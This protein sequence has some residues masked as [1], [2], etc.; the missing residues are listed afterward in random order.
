MASGLGCM[1]TALF[2]G[3]PCTSYTQ[4]IGIVAATGVAS[5]RVTQVAG[6]MFLLYGLCPKLAYV[7]AGIPK[8]IIGAVFLISAASI[9]FSGIDSIVSSPRTLKNTFIAGITLSMAVMLPYHC[10][11]T[12]A[13]WANSLSPFMNMLCTS[14]V[15]IAV[16]CGVT[17]NI[18]LN[19]V[20]KEKE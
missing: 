20:L 4:N 1:I 3:L 7:L 18:L 5:R 13:D 14:P 8:P 16:I 6:V 9:M 19:I 2:G 15:F 17:L 11:S 12:Y 10:S